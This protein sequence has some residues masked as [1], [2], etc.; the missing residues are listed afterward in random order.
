M[1]KHVRGP[2]RRIVDGFFKVLR[3]FAGVPALMS[4]SGKRYYDLLAQAAQN[5]E[6]TS[7]RLNELVHE[8]DVSKREAVIHRFEETYRGL[9]RAIKAVFNEAKYGLDVPFDKQ[10]LFH[11]CTQMKEVGGLMDEAV[12][13]IDLKLPN[14]PVE[15]TDFVGEIHKATKLIV[16]DIVNLSALLKNRNTA[17][18]SEE[19]IDEIKAAGRRIYRGA[20][21][22]WYA[23][24][25]SV[26]APEV[27]ELITLIT[28][29]VQLRRSLGLIER[30]SDYVANTV[31]HHS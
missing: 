29:M 17:S 9:K 26:T 4:P 10:R 28:L 23:K 14:L 12:E 22:E 3:W 6:S 16:V 13:T 30:L 15:V 31:L 8:A 1:K 24:R 21:R 19:A 2:G 25:Q 20:V 27:L 5:L 18:L 7:D 11:I